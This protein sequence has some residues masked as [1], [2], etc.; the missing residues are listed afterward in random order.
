MASSADALRR[1]ITSPSRF[2]QFK[3]AVTALAALALASCSMSASSLFGDSKAPPVPVQPA[4]P[5]TVSINTQGIKVALL[6]PL[7]GPGDTASVG[8]ALKQA[9]E[10]AMFDSGDPG[11]VL[12]TKDTRGNPQGAQAAAQEA[13]N[14]GAQII[15][16]PLLS[17]EVQAVQPLTRQRNVP[18]IAFSSSSTVAGGGTYLMSFLP[19]QEVASVTGYAIRQGRKNIA[20]MIPKDQYGATVERGL[21]EAARINGGQIVTMTRYARA[22]TGII[23]PI[24]EI[25]AAVN[26]PSK[27]VQALLLPEGGD[28]L[29]QIGHGLQTAGVT[30]NRVKT[31]GTGL[32]DGPIA[33]STPISLGGW[34]AGVAPQ[35]VTRFEQRYDST[36]GSTPPRLASLGYDAVSLSISMAKAPD[37]QR[38]SAAQITNPEGF[39]GVNGLFRFRSDG[40]IERGLAILEVTSTG[41][42]VVEGAPTRFNGASY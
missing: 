11:I 5:Q 34:Y 23:D 26:D 29:R 20:A 39:Q 32:W 25:A 7:S 2:A 21:V 8:R 31:L 40:R 27:N 15:L 30:P 28:Y 1:V 42:Q 41:P 14:E 18:M 17:S 6:V 24:K 3:V 33:R 19:E 4:A 9:G 10:L 36:Y 35:M 38:F 37:K 12:I 13:L 16:G 22:P